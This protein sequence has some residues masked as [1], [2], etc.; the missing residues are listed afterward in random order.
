M[1]RN[2]RRGEAALELREAGAPAYSVLR[3]ADS[4]AIRN[5]P[6]AS[7]SSSSTTLESGVCNSTAVTT[8]SET[9]STPTWAGPLIGQHTFDVLKDILGYSEDEIADIAATGALT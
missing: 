7:S 6:R 4:P 1:V 3:A 5:S 8:F 2:A 9:P